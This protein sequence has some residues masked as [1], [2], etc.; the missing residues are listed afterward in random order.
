MTIPG[1]LTY[2][3]PHPT[4][5]AEDIPML[6]MYG[7][8][9]RGPRFPE[10]DAKKALDLSDLYR[11]KHMGD[12]KVDAPTTEDLKNRQSPWRHHRP[13]ETV[14][15]HGA[16]EEGYVAVMD[17][18]KDYR[19]HIRDMEMRNMGLLRSVL[20]SASSKDFK[21]AHGTWLC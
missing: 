15:R 14:V 19:S 20:W 4:L 1:G 9:A 7:G 10:D 13:T 11:T 12:A 21:K 16:G 5:I 18:F 2:K 3:C 6:K 17:V 8:R